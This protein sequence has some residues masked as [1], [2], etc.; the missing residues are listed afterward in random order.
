MTEKKIQILGKE[1]MVRYC[2]ATEKCFEEISGK[3][4]SVFVP[5]T[6]TEKGKTVI[7]KPAEAMLG[8]YLTL[9]VAGIIAAY[10]RHDMEPPVTANDILYD[11]TPVDR[12][13]LVTAICELRNAWYQ[14]PNIVPKE[15]PSETEDTEK[16]KN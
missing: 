9:G 8:D 7:D 3:E 11:A 6:R 4:I 2:A 5:T 10:S 12:N 16:P 14:V 1:V 15:Q 13:T